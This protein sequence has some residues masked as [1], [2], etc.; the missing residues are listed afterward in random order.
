MIINNFNIRWTVLGP[1]EADAILRI[2]PYTVLPSPFSRE[3]LQ[4]ISRWY[5]QII[6]ET[7]G[8]QLIQLADSHGP[9]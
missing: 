7:S 6:Q 5:S 2:D 4:A 3:C 8:V 1:L 9:Q